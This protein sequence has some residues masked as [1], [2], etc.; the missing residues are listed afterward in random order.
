M[1]AYPVNFARGI[2]DKKPVDE[3]ADGAWRAQLWG[4]NVTDKYF[5]LNV[6]H[7]GDSLARLTGDPATYGISVSYRY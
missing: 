5:W 3:T 7:F 2:S 1:A 6:S 4:H